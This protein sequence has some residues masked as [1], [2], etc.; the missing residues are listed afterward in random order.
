MADRSG[1]HRTRRANVA[2]GRVTVHKVR[3]SPAEEE[4]LTAK[5]A[6]GQVTIVRLLIESALADGGET[7]TERRRL[8]EDLFA[9]RLELARVGVNV[10]QLARR[11]NLGEGFPVE[12]A[13]GFL[14][15]SR[16]LARRI[17]ETIDAVAALGVAA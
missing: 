5:A 15:E 9:A 7:P 4:L 14:V 3:T 17:D 1:L 10:N 13:R 2:G 6:A 8:L 12:E 16:A 11:A